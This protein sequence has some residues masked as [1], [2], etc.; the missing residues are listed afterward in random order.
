[1]W[2]KIGNDRIDMNHVIR[3]DFD[4]ISDSSHINFF[5]DTCM[6]SAGQYALSDINRIK[7]H[8]KSAKNLCKYLDDLILSGRI[9][10]IPMLVVDKEF[11]E[12]IK[13]VEFKTLDEFSKLK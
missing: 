2:I 3:Y 12:Y 9:K 8:V 11:E 10:D 6:A 1:M 7:V 5:M 4:G 13:G